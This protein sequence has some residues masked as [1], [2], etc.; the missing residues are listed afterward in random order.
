MNYKIIGNDG[1]TYGPASAEQLRQWLAQG[2]VDSR[3]AVFVDGASEWTFIGLLPDFAK[4][5]SGSPPVIAPLPPGAV[6]KTNGFATAGF[7]CGLLSWVCCCGCPFNILGLIFS[8]VALVQL[9]ANPAQQGRGLALTGLICSAASL[10][11]SLGLG[12]LDL[13]LKPHNVLWHFN[14]F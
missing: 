6:Q 4:E 8:I 10:L 12:F 11:L 9:G 1:K 14:Q 3:T 7:V 2:R 13:A 5:K